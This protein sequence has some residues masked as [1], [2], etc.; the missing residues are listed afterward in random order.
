MSKQRNFAMRSMVALA[1]AS[2]FPLAQAQEAPASKDQLETVIVTAQRRAEN[3]KD[4][5]MSI[6]TIKGDKLDTLT[7]GAGDIRILSGRTP[8]LNI[9]SDYGRAFPRFYIR[10]LGN[11]DFDLNASQPVGYVMDDIVMENAML[12]GF[13]VF[14]VDQVEVLRGPQGTLF[15][16]NSPAGVIKFDSAKPVFKQEGY[17]QFGVGN[18]SAKTAE[19]AFNIPVSDTVA[20]RFA[21]TSQ[22]RGNRVHN[23]NPDT[24]KGTR[25]FEGYGDNAFRIQALVKPT[26]DFDAL[27]NY[28][29]RNY[30]GSATL[31]RANILKQGTND[32]VDNFD[33]GSYPTDGVN[34]QKLKTQGGSIRLKYNLSDIT[35]HSITGY[36]K[37]DFNSRADVDGGY[38]AVYAPP[39]G[40]G[41]I[42]FV[43]ETADLLPNH[44][45]FSQEFRAESNYSGP[46]QW[47]GGLYY[48]NEAIQIDSISFDSLAPGNPQNIPYARQNQKSK[49][50]AAFGSVN[51]AVSDKLK[52][53]AGLRYTDDK[54]DFFASR[55]DY[56]AANVLV[57]VPHTLDSKTDNVSWDVSGTYELTKETNVFARIAT[58][59]RAPSMQGR[60]NGLGDVPT[61]AGVER[62]LSYEAGIKQDLF[63]KR[64]RLSAT[65]F[66]YRMK[67]KQLTAGSGGVN[68]NRLL[69]ADKVTGQGIELDLQANLGY[70]F[71]GSA[72]YSFNDTEIKDK[73]VRVQYCGNGANNL[74]MGCTPTNVAAPGYPGY[75]LIDGNDMPR[76][77]RNQANFSLKYST[78]VGNGELYAITDWSYRSKYNFFL[79]TA[80]EYTAKPLT[81]GGLRVGYKWGDGKYEVAAFGRNI[82]DKVVALS[83]IE[84]NNLTGM[85][86]EPRT[87]GATFKMN[88]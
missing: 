36:E 18:Y 41:R 39:Y 49:S 65:V 51:Y 55:T 1:V 73:N 60:L 28:H 20:L 50:W 27:F 56:N 25:D 23:T 87:Y 31:F 11:T 75:V 35:L 15:G 4:V 19:G 62:A 47:I 48:F 16:R 43:V 46:L 44:K 68:M 63:D 34:Y 54:K 40:P 21:G 42:P 53:R 13:P 8:S 67:D 86:N 71:S 2:A 58:G 38:G 32:L 17:V 12:K 10:G 29:Q 33:Y 84:F 37:L 74:G 3:I 78:E 14:D 22:H 80:V 72:G 6:A 64:A 5:P 88:F 82:T 69:N 30:H 52:L 85:L 24:T 83:A 45:Q 26:K 57:T 77:P 81:E 70:G 59:Y 9:E 61:M 66:Q 79:Y 76:A 7:A